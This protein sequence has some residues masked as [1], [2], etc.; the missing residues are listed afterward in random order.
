MPHQA[1]AEAALAQL[2]AFLA[3]LGLEL[4]EDKTRLVCVN[5]GEGFDFLGFHHRSVDGFSRAGASAS[6]PAGRR[7]APRK[8]RGS[9]S[10]SS[11]TGGC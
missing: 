10:A 9:G 6:W 7:H 11:P 8:Q 4:A 2:R 1:Q 5:D 3:E